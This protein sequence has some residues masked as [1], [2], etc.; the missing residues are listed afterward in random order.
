MFLDD[1]SESFLAFEPDTNAYLAGIKSNDPDNIFPLVGWKTGYKNFSPA[2]FEAIKRGIGGG[3]FIANLKQMR[4]DNIE[5]KFLDYLHNNAKKLVLAEQDVLNIIC[6][7]RIQALSLRHMIG[8]GYWKHYGQN[9]EKFTPKFYSQ[10][11]ITQARL[12]PIQLHYIG[13]KKPW[14]YPGEPK[15][16]L[17]FTYLCHTAF[18]QE[19]FEQLPKTIIDLYIKSRLPYRLKSYVC[20]N[21]HF[22]FTRD[23][24]QKLYRKLKNLLR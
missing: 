17:W 14:R 20:K 7:P 5:Q 4:Q 1:V 13:D 2:E 9:W 15:S 3:Y 23:F 18:A 10:E 6:Y 19:F 8:H 24:Y 12:H 21:P 22:I 11:E 16:S